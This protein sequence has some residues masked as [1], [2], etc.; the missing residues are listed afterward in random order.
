MN[1][2]PESAASRLPMRRC[3]PNSV[4]RCELAQAAVWDWQLS[5]DH[6]QV[7]EAWLRA[8]GIDVAVERDAVAPNGSGASIPTISARSS[9]RRIPAITAAT[10]SNANTGC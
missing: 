10:A 6:F 4:R 9:P 8:F 5:A 7:D 2:R 3:R 1:A